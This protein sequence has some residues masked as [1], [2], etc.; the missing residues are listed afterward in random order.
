MTA[1]VRTSPPRSLLLAVWLVLG[2][3]V[4][5]YG[6]EAIQGAWQT[7]ASRH[8]PQVTG[9]IVKHE[10][11][12]RRHCSTPVIHYRYMLSG[13]AF[14]SNTLVPPGMEECFRPEVASSVAARYPEGSYVRVYYD[15]QAPEN[16]VLLPGHMTRNAWLSVLIL[17]IFFLGWLYWGT[18]L[19]KS[20]DIAP[21]AG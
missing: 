7:L 4:L 8:W 16:A 5:Y 6:A 12:G 1:S 17:P 18:L 21:S 3:P 11:R 13:K 15:P 19:F 20:R 14:E 10:T 9:I 2:A